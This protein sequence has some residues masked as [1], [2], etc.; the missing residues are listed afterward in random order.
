MQTEKLEKVVIKKPL[1]EKEIQG[2]KKFY[3]KGMLHLNKNYIV[4]FENTYE[5]KSVEYDKWSVD[6]TR[7]DTEIEDGEIVA[8]SYES[9]QSKHTNSFTIKDT[10]NALLKEKDAIV[11]GYRKPEKMKGHCRKAPS[12]HNYNIFGNINNCLFHFL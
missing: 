6:G 3:L 8:T 5:L 1:T 7:K 10:I 2:F 12:K 11:I 4:E 9:I